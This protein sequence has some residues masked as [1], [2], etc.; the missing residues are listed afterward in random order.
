MSEPRLER[1]QKL[2][3]EAG[4]PG[5]ARFRTFAR[6]KGE[7]ITQQ[8][9]QEF[10][11]RQSERQVFGQPLRSDGAIASTREDVR[12]MADTIDFSKRAKQKSGAQYILTVIDVFSR[13]LYAEPQENKT[14]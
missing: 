10:V 2:F 14:P 4:K 1:L 7:N 13:K 5:A 6:Q 3:E 12:W 9:A 11:G 8:E